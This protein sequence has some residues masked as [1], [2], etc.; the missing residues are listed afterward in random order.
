[1]R[2]SEVIEFYGH[3]A[4]VAEAL[5]ISRQAVLQWPD[6]IPE[7]AAY[8]LQVITAGRLRVDPAAYPNKQK[9]AG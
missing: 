7:G 9:R 3:P 5:D 4:K 2:K 8:K 1:M 6:P